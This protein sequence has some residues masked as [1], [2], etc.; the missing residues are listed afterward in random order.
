MSESSIQRREDRL[1]LQQEISK[2]RARIERL[3]ESLCWISEKDNTYVKDRELILHIARS[4]LNVH[5]GFD[6]KINEKYQHLIDDLREDCEEKDERKIE[7]TES[8]FDEAWD[9]AKCRNNVDSV[10]DEL[11]KRLFEK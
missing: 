1:E 9:A 2:L 11:K 7:I 6:F 5:C 3:T 10:K 8:E 4:S